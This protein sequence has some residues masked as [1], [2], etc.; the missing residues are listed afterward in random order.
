MRIT[1]RQALDYFRSDDL[2]GLGME[3]DALRRKLHRENV[4]TYLL[5]R[6]IHITNFCDGDG[7][8]RAFY[9][10]LSA[11]ISSKYL[12]DFETIHRQ[13]AETIEIGGTGMLVQGVL[14][15]DLKIEWLEQLL[16]GIKQIFP[17]IWLDC[18][19][20]PEIVAIATV[21]ELTVRDVV[22]RLRD[23][24]LDS[25]PGDGADI[26]ADARGFRMRPQCSMEDWMNVH[27]T[28]HELGI[29]STAAMM[30]GVGETMEER[31][32]FLEQIRRLQEATGGFTA[33]FPWSC[34]P[35]QA[36][37]E[38]WYE[39]TAVEYL[40]VLAISRLYLENIENVQSSWAAQGLK[41][42][43]LALRFGGNDAGSV[44][45][46]ESAI[47]PAAA[48]RSTDEEQLRRVIRDAGFNPA[49]RDTGYTTCFLY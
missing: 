14:H 18:F 12:L 41:V 32:A 45:L 1:Q 7:R 19:S 49:Q 29:K 43:Q 48:S 9:R 10:P 38:A 25:L 15:P 47:K 2:I 4:V 6:K 23:A 11:A 33:F 5:D 42:L 20:A 30:F 37:L 27:R 39:A 17:Q 36:N 16:R 13:V 28:A 35:G 44:L 3:A 31:I 24:G 8:S 26:L 34:R 21:S 46:E 22:A 40:K